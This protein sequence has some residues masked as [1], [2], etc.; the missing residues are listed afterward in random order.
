MGAVAIEKHYTNDPTREGPDHRFSA[1]PEIMKD[2]ANGVDDIMALVDRQP[3]KQQ[4]LNWSINRSVDVL[5]LQRQTLKK[6][7][8]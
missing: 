8:K 2:I 1:T 5:H 7:K 4:R 6:G 3:K